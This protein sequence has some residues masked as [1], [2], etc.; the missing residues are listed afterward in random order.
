MTDSFVPLSEFQ[1]CRQEDTDSCRTVYSEVEARPKT[2][3]WMMKIRLRLQDLQS[4]RLFS[5]TN[6]QFCASEHSGLDSLG[7]VQYY[8]TLDANIDHNC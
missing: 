5:Y 2:L 3:W 4:M 1:I 7:N 6:L 8:D